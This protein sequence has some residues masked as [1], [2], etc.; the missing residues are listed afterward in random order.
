VATEAYYYWGRIMIP[1]Y[2]SV[3]Q[4]NPLAVTYS[5]SSGIKVYLN[6]NLLYSTPAYGNIQPGDTPLNIGAR[7]D[8]A[9]T[10]YFRGGTD[11]VGIWKT[12]RTQNEIVQIMNKELTWSENG[13][14]A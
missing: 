5:I 3:N 13:L 6:Y 1:Y 2:W 12:V 8:S 14:I 7:V 10:E 9:Y 4:W 11:D